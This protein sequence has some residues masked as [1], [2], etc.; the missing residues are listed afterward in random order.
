MQTPMQTHAHSLPQQRPQLSV[1][2]DAQ[3]AQQT[4]QQ[5]PAS[6]QKIVGA[7]QI[8][9][10]PMARYKQL[11]FYAAKLPTM[12]AE[13]HVADNKV[14]GCVS[15]VGAMRCG[16]SQRGRVQPGACLRL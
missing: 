10:D 4:A 1:R 2:A 6:L 16:S 9:P 12:A 11:L 14:E 5:L 15:Q 3:P 8:V 7:F 13:D